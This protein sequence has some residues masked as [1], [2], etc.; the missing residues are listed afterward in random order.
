MHGIDED[1][2]YKPAEVAEILH[3]SSG[4]VYQAMRYHGLP[5]F[6]LGLKNGRR[7]P[8]S[9]LIE[10]MNARHEQFAPEVVSKRVVVNGSDLEDR[11]L[12]LGYSLHEAGIA[13]NLSERTISR[14]EKA[15]GP[16]RINLETA[17]KLFEVF[18]D[19]EIREGAAV[20]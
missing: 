5:F 11:R 15:Q 12:D 6:R 3:M 2:L 10:W 18:G 14:I 9:Q 7:I 8:G 17:D 4:W 16:V 20:G 1:T 19:L 13:T